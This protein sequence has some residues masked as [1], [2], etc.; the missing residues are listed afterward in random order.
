MPT[1]PTPN[2]TVGS[3]NPA[4]GDGNAPTSGRRGRPLSPE[5][6]DRILQA[7]LA[8]LAD[9]GYARLRLDAL[10]ASAGVAKTTIL[11]R[12]PSKAAGVAAA[13]QRLPLPH[14]RAPRAR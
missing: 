3:E 10:A 8:M 13:V 2:A 6:N 1:Q 11:R 12:W 9:V 5:F 4:A 14:A 7:A